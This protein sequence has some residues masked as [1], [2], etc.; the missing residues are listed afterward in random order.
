MQTW[1]NHFSTYLDNVMDYGHSHMLSVL[2]KLKFEERPSQDHIKALMPPEWSVIFTE[3][4]YTFTDIL[5]LLATKTIYF[6]PEFEFQFM[7]GIMSLIQIPEI[8][9]FLHE[10][11]L[12]KEVS[13]YNTRRRVMLYA[14]IIEYGLIVEDDEMKA[15]GLVLLNDRKKLENVFNNQIINTLTQETIEHTVL[16]REG[17]NFHIYI[18]NFL[19]PLE[20]CQKLP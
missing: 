1:Q 5:G 14:Q 19:Q 13:P 4:D 2:Q 12:Q 11:G 10:L 16:S 7:M 6:R 8:A 3:Q 20:L 17:P 9:A 18:D 15:I